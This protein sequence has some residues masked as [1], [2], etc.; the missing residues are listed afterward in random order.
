[1]A[2]TSA[3]SSGLAPS[4]WDEGLGAE[5]EYAR[6]VV[7][8]ASGVCAQ[9]TVVVDHQPT[10]GAGVVLGVVG[11][12]FRVLGAVNPLF[13]WLPSQNGLLAD[14]PQRHS[15]AGPSSSIVL[16]SLHRLIVSTFSSR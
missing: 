5:P 7:R 15:I 8:A 12:S 6:E 3:I 9:S 11:Y 4:G 14:P 1:M 13:R 10:V 16:P 2:M